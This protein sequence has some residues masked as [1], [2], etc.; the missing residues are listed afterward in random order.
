M[1]PKLGARPPGGADWIHEIK[2]DGYRMQLHVGPEGATWFTR[3]GHDWSAKLAAFTEASGAEDLPDCVLDGELVAVDDEG[4]SNFSALRSAIGRGDVEHL[5]FWAFDCLA[6]LGRDMRGLSLEARKDALG[7]VLF[8]CGPSC[9]RIRF[10]EPVPATDARALLKAACA[11]ELEGIVSKRLDAPYVGGRA[12]AW[13]KAKCRPSETVVIGGVE[14]E[15]AVRLGALLVGVREADGSLRYVGRVKTGFGHNAEPL[16]KAL[17]RRER[18]ASP[19]AKDAP[20]KTS[21]I[22][23]VEPDLQAEVEIAEWT[24]SGRLRQASF[25]G[26]REDLA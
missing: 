12:D 26:L 22:R 25:K 14:A 19:F 21:S 17:R 6:F 5:V 7:E 9:E 15:G 20:R 13:V 10:V 24:S 3:N 4:R 23:W 1:H 18:A 2:H 8:P 11:T 16:I